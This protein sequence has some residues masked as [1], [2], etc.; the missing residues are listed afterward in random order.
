MKELY[1]NIH[2]LYLALRKAFRLMREPFKEYL[3]YTFWMI[4]IG[5]PL[6]HLAFTIYNNG[7]YFPGIF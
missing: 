7:P 6:L 1:Y 3:Y 4:V 5:F 2:I